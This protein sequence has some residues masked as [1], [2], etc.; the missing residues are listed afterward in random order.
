MQG[1]RIL[2]VAQA[3]QKG[4]FKIELWS[5]PLDGSS[6]PRK[7]DEGVYGYQ[8]TPDRKAL[9]W[10]A[11][12]AG[13]ARSCSLLRAAAD[14]STPALLLATNVA[15]FDLATDGSRVLVQQ[16]HHGA[17]RAVD[18]AI[19]ATDAPP[20]DGAVEP[21]AIEVDPSSRFVDARGRRIVYAAMSTARA[22]VYLLDVP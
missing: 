20:R 21:V 22:G 14:G 18:L 12:C 6:P 1:D 10:K 9:L 19:V 13:G 11:R 17:A 16:P 8:L 2:Y 15:G 7:V 3:P 4:D 5:A